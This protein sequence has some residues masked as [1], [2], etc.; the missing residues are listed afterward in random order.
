MTATATKPV[1]RTVEQEA[2]GQ[3]LLEQ[4][5]DNTERAMLAKLRDTA[6][7][8]SSAIEAA[9]DHLE[10]SVL[11]ASG[12]THLRTLLDDRV[13]DKY[14]MPIM[15][16]QNGFLTDKD[17]N[18]PTKN[19]PNP[20]PY[21]MPIVREC[22][23]TALL[24]GLRWVDNEFN[25]IAGKMMAVLNGLQRKVQEFPGARDFK[26]VVGQPVVNGGVAAVRVA[27]SGFLNGEKVE[28]KDEKD[29]TGRVF[30]VAVRDTDG[31]DAWK[32]KAERRGWKAMLQHLK[33]KPIGIAEP[34]DEPAEQPATPP[35]VT[36]EKPTTKTE[37]LANELGAGKRLLPA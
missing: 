17:P 28:L 20:Q 27:I 36:A 21:A 35:V 1:T 10:K 6:G 33:G 5:L 15:N 7:R 9:T 8:Y 31:I 34:D 11:I 30:H 25:I 3:T 18:R 32:G 13:M 19:N 4:I 2:N 26:A 12:I 23:I 22:C 29:Q 14:V 37:Q 16:S 24:A